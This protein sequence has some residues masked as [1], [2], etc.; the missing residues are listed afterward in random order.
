VSTPAWDPQVLARIAHLQLRA[1]AAVAGWRTGDHRSKRTQSNVEFVDYKEY[2]PGDPIRHL[3]WR[4][5]ARADRLVIRRHAAE[6]EVPV[7]LVVDLSG[8]LGTGSEE[9]PELD[10]TKHGAAVSLA[11]TLAVFLC[12][13]G[14]PVGLQ[15]IGGAGSPVSQMP[16]RCSS[17]HLAQL[18]GALA[19]SRPDGKAELG[20]ALQR[21]A[22]RLPKRGVVVLISDLME[23]PDQWGPSLGALA[24]SGSDLRVVH[25]YEQAEWSLDWRAPTQLFSPEGGEPLAVDPAVA[26][27]TFAEVLDEYLAEVQGWLS[28]Y[29]AHYVSLSAGSAVDEALASVLRAER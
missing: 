6:T 3:D 13:R 23:E 27:S 16:P 19:S 18:I 9:R 2:S 12:R 29:G 22:E 20:S 5:A 7:T 25:V 1:R 4:V 10:S 28:R 8:D 21:I 14:D 11:A 17:G 26:R 15:L 24:R